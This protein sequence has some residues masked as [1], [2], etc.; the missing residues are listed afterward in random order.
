MPRPLLALLAALLAVGVA[1]AVPP[2]AAQ[3]D[4][5]DL[6]VE[7]T[8]VSPAVLTSGD[9]LVVSGRITNTTDAEL[10]APNVRLLMQKHVPGSVEALQDWVDGSSIL[11]V[12]ALTGWNAATEDGDDIPAGGSVPFTIEISTD[13][14]FDQFSAWGPR[15]IE[16]DAASGT[17]AGS[18]RTTLLWYPSEPPI[19]SPAEITVL[20]PLT[21]TAQEWATA[22]DEGVAVGEVAAPRLLEVLDAVG[23]DA[24][25]AVDPA[26]LDDDPPGAATA[27]RTAPETDETTAPP[28]EDESGDAVGEDETGSADDDTTT[29]TEPALDRLIDR[30]QQTDSRHDLIGLGYADADLTALSATGGEDLWQD[31]TARAEELFDEAGLTVEQVSWPPGS[32]SAGALGTL[33]GGDTEAVV[34]DADDVTGV[35][36]T[37]SRATVASPEGPLDALLADDGL[38]EALTTTAM[39]GAQATQQALA[40]SAVMTRALPLGAAGFLVALPRDVAAD[41]LGQLGDRT[42][43]LLEAPWL[44]PANLR[45][46]L[47]RTDASGVLLEMPETIEQEDA[48]TASDIDSLLAAREVVEA[49]AE[50]AGPEIRE[51]HEPGMLQPLSATLSLEPELRAR[52]LGDSASAT[53]QLG[54]SIRVESGSDVLLISEGGSM[55]IAITNTLSVPAQVYVQLVPEQTR[56]QATEVP[57]ATLPPGETTTVRVPITAV[58][59]GD[60]TIDV[61]VLASRGG[62][63]LAP[64]ASF[65]VRVR[66]GWENIGTGIVAGL[67]SIAFV[68]GLIR[69]IRRGGRRAAAR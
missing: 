31:G 19:A 56:V 6:T 40:L 25:L 8:S 52:L 18:A 13:G 41:G 24:S 49:Y 62:Q 17:A 69:T 7:L 60:V 53:E 5:G 4:D 46:L 33:A 39:S 27:A 2:P 28:E 10:P 29:T 22:T 34:L 50:A 35:E 12:A 15:G 61:R 65:S 38:G 58:A 43:A 32:L 55:P 47:G 11:N 37:G 48:V 51:A 9:D 26:L 16:I 1:L 54:S 64:P 63:D 44:E 36:A 30:L 23:P 45:S 67:L 42:S 20:V 59:N 68:I 66:A 3:A 14:T 21:P 57:Q